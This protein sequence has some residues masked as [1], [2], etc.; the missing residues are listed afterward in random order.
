M[1][2]ALKYVTVLVNNN[3]EV[4]IVLV[5][6]PHRHDLF[7]ELCVNK[8]VQKLNRQVEKI[9]KLQSNVKLL[10]I[11]LDRNHFTRHG[12]HLNFKGTELFSQQL[13]VIVEQFCV[14]EQIAPISIPWKVP[15]SGSNNTET[16]DTNI[17]N[18][19]T[20]PAQLP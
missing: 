10:E 3:K 15:I 13:A 18:G 8:E 11:K 20:E 6:S 7:P 16:L 14:K 19:K 2:D 5:N 17:E 12:V 9:M 4:S 1:N